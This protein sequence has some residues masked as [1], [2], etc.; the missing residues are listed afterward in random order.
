MANSLRFARLYGLVAV[1]GGIDLGAQLPAAG[2]LHRA[3]CEDS[4]AGRGQDPKSR[5]GGLTLRK[6]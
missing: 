1:S 5:K 6:H 4:W 2:S 3:G